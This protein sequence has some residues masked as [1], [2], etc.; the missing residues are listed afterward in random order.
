MQNGKGSQPFENIVWDD[1]K[2]N[3]FLDT[4]INN[5]ERIHQLTD[6]THTGNIDHVVHEFACFLKQ[7]ALSV[8]RKTVGYENTTKVKEEI[9]GTIQNVI[10]PSLPLNA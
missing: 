3:L 9:I 10:M 8:F 2:V 4:Q 7:N 6:A 5:N 1:R